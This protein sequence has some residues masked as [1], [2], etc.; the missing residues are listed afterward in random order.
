MDR[1]RLPR[2]L[3]FAKMRHPRI[4]V[5]QLLTFGRRVLGEVR[6]AVKE[7]PLY[8]STKFSLREGGSGRGNESWMQY[9]EDRPAWRAFSAMVP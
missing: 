9:A 7:A 2:K 6:R 5:G 8:V 4:R 3:A 1:E